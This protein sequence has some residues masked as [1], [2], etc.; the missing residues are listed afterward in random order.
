MVSYSQKIKILLLLR[1][2]LKNQKQRKS[3]RYWVKPKYLHRG[4][5]GEFR[6]I[7]VPIKRSAE[8]GEDD[9]LQRFYQYTRLEF[10][11]FMKL[12]EMLREQ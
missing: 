12:L 9:A 4:S 2:R 10:S 5:D 3:R 8:R 1:Q 11:A 7:Y 6:R